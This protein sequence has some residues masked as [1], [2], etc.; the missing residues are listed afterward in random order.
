MLGYYR[1]AAR[2]KFA[3]A[4]GLGDKDAGAPRVHVEKM[5]VLWG[6]GDPVLPISVG[7]A[8]VKDLGPDC[9]MVTVPGAGHFV[10]EEAPDVVLETL[11]SFLGG[12]APAKQAPANKAPAKKAPAKKAPAQ[13]AP[14][15]KA[16]AK[17]APVVKGEGS[18]TS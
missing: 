2:P 16:P 7:E 10:I 14:V 17:K 18:E 6:A 15:K 9:V 1:A 12:D 11:R 5:M 8:V 3:A 4:L 13:K